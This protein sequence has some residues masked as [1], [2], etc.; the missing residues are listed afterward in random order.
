M[1]IHLPYL[2]IAVAWSFL[3]SPVHA[4]DTAILTWEPSPEIDL[5]GYKIYMS[6]KSHEYGA[7]IADIDKKQTT[8]EVTVKA[9]KDTRYY[10]V[11]RAYNKA[12]TL[13]FPSNEASKIIKG[14]PAM[15]S[16]R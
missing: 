3:A 8:C 13:S 4:D 6:T 9:T 2:M 12:G 14:T 11:V 1:N 5:G 16:T 15:A 10:F 7:P